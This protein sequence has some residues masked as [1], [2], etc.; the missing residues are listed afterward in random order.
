MAKDYAKYATYKKVRAN[1]SRFCSMLGLAIALC[2][3][4]IGLFLFKSD[5]KIN[6]KQQ[7]AQQTEDKLKQKILE[8]PTPTPPKPKFDFYNILPQDNLTLSSLPAKAVTIAAKEASISSPAINPLNSILSVSPKQ[9]AIEE[10]KKQL[11]QELTQL[12]NKAYTLIL[13]TFH[14]VAEAEQYQAQALLKGFPVHNKVVNINKTVN[15]QL[16]MGPYSL[17]IASQQQKRLNAAGMQATLLKI[18]S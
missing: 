8:A 10:A 11:D 14:D 15:Y 6:E 13:G 17:A 4:V 9:V 5:K 1:R 7:I 3:L 18:T 16:F 2:V 12:S